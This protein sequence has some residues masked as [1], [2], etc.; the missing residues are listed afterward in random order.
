M[1]GGPPKLY[2]TKTSRCSMATKGGLIRILAERLPGQVHR[3]DELALGSVC[4]PSRSLLEEPAFAGKIL[5][6]RRKT[7][8][9]SITGALSRQ[10][11]S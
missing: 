4:T 11:L 1:I 7:Q 2:D 10:G 3:L 8:R 9:L 6:N 5:G